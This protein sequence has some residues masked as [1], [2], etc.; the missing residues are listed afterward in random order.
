MA[1]FLV[2]P[3]SP[4]PR[5]IK[6][7]PGI[8]SIGRADSNN[9]QITDASVSSSHC[10]VIV[11]GDQVT[12]RDLGSTNG[13][14]VNGAPVQ[15]A[16]LQAGQTIRLG[17][18]E[19]TFLAGHAGPM[20]V[21]VGVRPASAPAAPAAIP[22]AAP[23]PPAAVTPAPSAAPA[24][25]LVAVASPPVA[26]P[27]TAAAP[28]EP[29]A[30]PPEVGTSLP[31]PADEPAIVTSAHC[32]FHPK[33]PSRFFCGKCQR[34][35]CYSCVNAYHGHHA[36]RSCG[37]ECQPVAYQRLAGAADR[38]FFGRIA[39]ALAYPFRGGGIMMLIFG[40]AVLA[41]FEISLLTVGMANLRLKIGGLFLTLFTG[42][43]FFSFLQNILH[44]TSSGDP[45]L[46]DLPSF[47]NAWDD[48]ALPFFR[49]L[50]LGLISFGAAIGLEVWGQV[51]DNQT[52]L[53]AAMA[54]R[55]LGFIYFPMAFLAVA[56]LDSLPAAN[57]LVVIPSVFKVPLEYLVALL[58]FGAW[59]GSRILGSYVLIVA[60]PDS[61]GTHSMTQL[62]LM[63]LTRLV[64]AIFNFYLVVVAVRLLGLIFVTRKEKL[65][66][67]G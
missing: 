23:L 31:H 15:E 4:T 13:T 30:P 1:R 41:L 62:V 27:L 9:F 8:N 46:P 57:P 24:A 17:N 39:G 55:F 29:T 44:S 65:G 58:A 47:G 3:Q 37:G 43:Y 36:C 11:E 35:Y 61:I 45:E 14:F 38:G 26:R 48:L 21:S 51:S 19:M 50:G 40:M 64:W 66:W 25:A 18:V 52:V 42:G 67:L 34:Y 28:T 54:T 6:L 22:I 7:T 33:M 2:N 60:F 32:K 20:K 49:L 12:L 59:I 5:E 10:L 53:Y 63:I 16:V 56:M